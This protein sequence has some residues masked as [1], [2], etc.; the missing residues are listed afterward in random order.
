[1]VAIEIGIIRLSSIGEGNSS[2]KV[3]TIAA[4]IAPNLNRSGKIIAKPIET[5]RNV[6]LPSRV[7]SKSFLLPHFFPISAAV[8]SASERVSI[9]KIAM[10]FS[11]IRMVKKP[12]M[13]T[14]VAPVNLLLSEALTIGPKNLF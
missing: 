3:A 14:E 9:A 2:I 12:D 1:M 8:A 5:I 13:K 11:K 7:L 10:F 4:T 6:K